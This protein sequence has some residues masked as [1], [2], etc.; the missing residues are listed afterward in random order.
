MVL[1]ALSKYMSITGSREYE[2]SCLQ[3]VSALERMVDKAGNTVHVLDGETLQVVE[4]FR[5]VYYD[6]EAV[7]D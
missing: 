1:L 3:V 2:S 7:L 6:G 4:E 5:T